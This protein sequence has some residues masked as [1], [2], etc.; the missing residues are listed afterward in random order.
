M[1]DDLS[2]VI[3]SNVKQLMEMGYSIS[4]DDYGVGYSNI[5]RVLKL[6]LKI[7]KIDKTLVDGLST[8]GGKSVFKNTVNMLKDINLELVVEGV[9]TKEALDQIVA[10][11]CDFVQGFYYSKPVP[12]D[13]F[14]E[15]LKEHNV[16]SRS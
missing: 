10:M 16:K 9:E 14:I 7:V 15:Y 3:D 11:D 12:E 8:S 13:Q 2:T 1:Y 4:L 5:H 6:P